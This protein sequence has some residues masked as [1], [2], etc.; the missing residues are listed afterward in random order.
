M[1]DA[2]HARRNAF[3]RSGSV[4]V[5]VGLAL[6]GAIAWSIAHGS[7]GTQFERWV[8]TLQRSVVSWYAGSPN[9]L[10]GVRLYAI[11]FVGGLA[12]S[13][14][15]CILGML[16][17]NLA[18]VGASRTKGRMGAMLV[19][20]Q[21]VAGVI[22]VTASVGLFASLFFALFV[23]YRGEINLVVGAL[24]I[25][26]GM[27]LAGII[28]IP[29]TSLIAKAPVAAGPFVVGIAFALIASPCASP[30]LIAV[31]GK[32]AASGSAVQSVLAMVAYAIGYTAILWLASVFAGV[33]VASRR[34][35]AHGETIVRL[36]A[37]ALVVLG[38]GTAVYG[39]RQL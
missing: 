15:P 35:L 34:L 33:A 8:A 26:M 11:A 4:R 22:V 28:R 13:I 3:A 27:W 32:A 23:T 9:A 39:F 12:A 1:N 7:I 31:L 16:P 36:S 30:I 25:V 21:F 5:L 2:T 29:M 10:V 18:F 37:I 17:V 14:S 19:A 6:V 20:S 24:M 38:I